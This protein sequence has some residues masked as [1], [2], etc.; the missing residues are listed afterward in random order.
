[1]LF[2]VCNG[3]SAQD[4]NTCSVFDDIEQVQ[5]HD[6]ED[7]LY[8]FF[9]YAQEGYFGSHLMYCNDLKRIIQYGE[10]QFPCLYQRIM[11]NL[12]DFKIEYDKFEIR[13]FYKDT[14]LASYKHSFDSQ[15]FS[16]YIFLRNF[17]I[18]LD[19]DDFVV[20]DSNIYGDYVSLKQNIAIKLHEHNGYE[21]VMQKVSSIDEKEPEMNLYPLMVIFVYDSSG[22]QPHPLFDDYDEMYISGEYKQ[23]VVQ[24][25]DYL[26]SKYKAGENFFSIPILH[27]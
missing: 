11:D 15:K 10:S 5:Y 23:Q 4:T 20:T 25:A 8:E 24:M 6:I 26:C 14:F 1:M 18:L 2:A 13:I 3:L 9:F 27:Q 16:T 17:V 12:E 21:F 19:K 7:S 22:L